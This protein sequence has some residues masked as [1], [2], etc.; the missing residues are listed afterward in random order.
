MLSDLVLWLLRGVFEMNCLFLS[1]DFKFQVTQ[2]CS[3]HPLEILPVARNAKLQSMYPLL[4]SV[5]VRWFGQSDK[6]LM[7]GRSKCMSGLVFPHSKKWFQF[8]KQKE[9]AWGKVWEIRMGA[10]RQNFFFLQ[11]RSNYCGGMSVS[12]RRRTCLKS[13]VGR[14]FW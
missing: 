1:G 5:T 2:K 13:V 11:K 12:C 8:R 6:V 9:I 7:H 3:F 10:V 14:R 4:E